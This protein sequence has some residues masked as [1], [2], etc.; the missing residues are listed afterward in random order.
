MIASR[1]GR[2]PSVQAM[3]EHDA[4][5]TVDVTTGSEGTTAPTEGISVSLGF[6]MKEKIRLR[7]FG[8][9]CFF[10]CL[11]CRNHRWTAEKR[12]NHLQNP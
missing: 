9:V 2:D 8:C 1:V 5:A 10:S 4:M 6:I 7:G 11:Q 12:I 3:S